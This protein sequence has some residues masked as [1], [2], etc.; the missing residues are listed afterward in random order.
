M[1]TFQHKELSVGILC[2]FFSNGLHG[3]LES[4]TCQ[5]NVNTQICNISHSIVINRQFPT[6]CFPLVLPHVNQTA[7]A[8]WL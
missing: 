5:K 3:F 2:L 8:V 4:H 1:M 6:L 7:H